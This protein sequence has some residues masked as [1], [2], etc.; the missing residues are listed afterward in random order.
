MVSMRRQDGSLSRT[1]RMNAVILMVSTLIG[2]LPTLQEQI[3]V[4]IYPWLLVG[5][6]LLNA[7]FRATTTQP[8]AG[9]G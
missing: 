1:Q 5:L 7:Y 9:S 6:S 3:P 8:L 4:E 2:L